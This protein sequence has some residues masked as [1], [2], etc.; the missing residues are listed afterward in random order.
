[1]NQLNLHKEFSLLEAMGNAFNPNP[2]KPVKPT[3]NQVTLIIDA[4]SLTDFIVDEIANN[5][6][7]SRFQEEMIDKK[8]TVEGIEVDMQAE[9]G[10]KFEYWEGGVRVYNFNLDNDQLFWIDSQPVRW[11][12]NILDQVYPAVEECLSDR[13]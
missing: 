10:I 5:W 1:M 11:N 3:A 8:I 13:L 6:N 4:D 9:W 2:A 7:R 12:D